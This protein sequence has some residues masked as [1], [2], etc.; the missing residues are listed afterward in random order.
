MLEHQLRDFHEYVRRMRR[1]NLSGSE[2]GLEAVLEH[3][4]I[5]E[6]I[7]QKDADRAQELA[8]L[9]MRNAYDNMI[10]NGLLDAYDEKERI[11]G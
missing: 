7:C 2:R 3:K 5:M 9:H 10:K 4:K 6:A 8:A 1:Q 11:D